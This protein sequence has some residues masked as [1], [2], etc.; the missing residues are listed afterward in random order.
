MNQIISLLLKVNPKDRPDAETLLKN[1]TLIK[2][3]RYGEKKENEF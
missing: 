1:S 2:K 3:C